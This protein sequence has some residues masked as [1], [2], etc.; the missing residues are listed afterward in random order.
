MRWTAGRSAVHA[1]K[2]R[3]HRNTAAHGVA[4]DGEAIVDSHVDIRADRE[5]G[6]RSPGGRECCLGFSHFG[7]DPLGI[8]TDPERHS[9]GMSGC[10]RNDTLASAGHVDGHFA[11]IHQCMKATGEPVALDDFS[12]EIALQSHDEGLEQRD[13][14]GFLAEVSERRIAAPDAEGHAP[15]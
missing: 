14:G 5:L 4:R 1:A 8:R 3:R 6:A 2:A 10:Q 12:A 15:A 13:G 11:L 9:V 7:T